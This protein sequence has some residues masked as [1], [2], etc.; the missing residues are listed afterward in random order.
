MSYATG[1]Y[2]DFQTR[3]HELA[4]KQSDVTSFIAEG[5][6][7]CFTGGILNSKSITVPMQMIGHWERELRLKK[8]QLTPSGSAGTVLGQTI[9]TSQW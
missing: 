3:L 2:L 5:S 7:Y 6:G 1:T 4:Q 8:Y 9:F